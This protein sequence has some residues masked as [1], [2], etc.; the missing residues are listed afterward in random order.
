MY[1]L[2]A[3]HCGGL[4]FETLRRSRS[5]SF[6]HLTSQ[7]GLA[8]NSTFAALLPL[9]RSLANQWQVKCLLTGTNGGDLPTDEMQFFRRSRRGISVSERVHTSKSSLRKSS[10]LVGCNN[11][12]ASDFELCSNILI[13]KLAYYEGLT[14]GP[15]DN[16]CCL[17]EDASR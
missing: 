15:V 10:R 12:A 13:M 3:S 5:Q 16:H 17:K 2:C 4:S 11:A 6:L 14:S 9:I 7:V 8:N 1:S